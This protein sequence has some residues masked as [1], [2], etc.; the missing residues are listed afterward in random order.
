MLISHECGAQLTAIEPLFELT[1]ALFFLVF[2]TLIISSIHTIIK[3]TNIDL[4]GINLT[5]W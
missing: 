4:R 3:L 1:H 2:L 5:L